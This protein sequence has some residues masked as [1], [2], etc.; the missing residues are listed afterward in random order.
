L[1]AE[2]LA[3][4]GLAPQPRGR[5]QGMNREELAA[6]H[7]ALEVVLAWPD[8]VRAEVARWLAAPAASKPNGRDPHPP[9]LAPTEKASE[10]EGFSPRAPRP[11]AYAGPQAVTSKRWAVSLRPMPARNLAPR[12]RSTGEIGTRCKAGERGPSTSCGSSPYAP[13]ATNRGA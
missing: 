3:D 9:P 5:N 7:D 11:T 13:C 1:T 4:D 8:S 2:P 12:K 6:L 10:T